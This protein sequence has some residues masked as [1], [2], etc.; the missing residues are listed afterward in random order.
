MKRR[1]LKELFRGTKALKAGSF[2][3]AVVAIVI[4]IAVAANLFVTALP[5]SFTKIDLTSQK[6]YSLSAQTESIVSALGDDIDITWI[7]QNGQEDT[8]L[9][10]LLGRYES[11]SRKIHVTKLDPDAYPTFTAKYTSDQVY[12]NSLVVESGTRSRYISYT[13]L[14]VYDYSNYY[15]TGSYSVSFAG[16]NELT[17]AIDYVTSETVPVLYTLT[18][19]GEAT[20]SST[21]SSAIASDNIEVKSL[22]VITENAVPEDATCVLIYAPKNDI[23]TEEQQ[24]LSSYAAEG[25]S[26]LLITDPLETGAYRPNLDALTAEYGMSET[27]GIVIEGS[28]DHYAYGEPYCLLPTLGSHT[29]TS[30]LSSGGY[31]VLLPLAHGLKLTGGTAKALLSTSDSAYTK[32]AGYEMTTYEKEEG[33]EEGQFVLGAIASTDAENEKASLIWVTSS[34]L[35][36][37]MTNVQVAGGNEDFFLNCLNYV[38]GEESKISIRAKSLSYDYLTVSSSQAAVLRVLMVVMIP[39]AF[40]VAG[41][42]VRVR[43]KRR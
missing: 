13:D 43:R 33:D 28:G 7:V 9:G 26:I 41:I 38:C 31:Y 37:D 19:H 27:E 5:E 35:L 10:T 24:I 39:A 3:F 42:A 21:Y 18:G 14:Y 4:A 6:L 29:I 23:S 30:S 2:S 36:D 1:T 34:S 12:N 25:G 20:L 15:T 22:S 40:V 17:S 16:E 8:T 11:L 32:K